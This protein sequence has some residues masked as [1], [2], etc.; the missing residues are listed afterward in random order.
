MVTMATTNERTTLVMQNCLTLSESVIGWIGPC[1]S[2]RPHAELQGRNS[3][4]RRKCSSQMNFILPC[5]WVS[6]SSGVVE[7]L[8]W[9]CMFSQSDHQPLDCDRNTLHVH[10]FKLIC[11]NCNI[12]R[13]K[14]NLDGY[15]F[16]MYVEYKTWHT[17]SNPDS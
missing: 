11:K 4:R 17:Q 13:N 3:P 14:V 8:S 1:L 12:C 9:S 16:C 10:C 6:F 7:F 5:L 15:H 2:G